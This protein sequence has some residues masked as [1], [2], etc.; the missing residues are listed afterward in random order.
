ML[1]L[2]LGGNL[3]KGFYTDY[4]SGFN[5]VNIALK[6]D[7]SFKLGSFHLPV[8]ASYIVN[9]YREKSYFTLSVFLKSKL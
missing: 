5:I 9:P 1:I 6:Y 8:T 3:N 4:K 2:S 7:T